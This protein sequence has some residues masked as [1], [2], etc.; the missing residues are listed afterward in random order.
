M[1]PCTVQNCHLHGMAVY[2]KH[3]FQCAPRSLLSPKPSLWHR[4]SYPSRTAL[5]VKN[6]TAS[7]GDVRRQGLNPWLRTIPWRR[8]WQPTPVFLPGESQ[9][10]RS[11]RG[12]TAHGVARVGHDLAT[13]ATITSRG[14]FRSRDQTR[15][16]YISCICRQVLYH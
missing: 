15:I 7:A 3:Q 10:Q 1:V 13:K 8:A 4:P 11:L 12:Y 14:P 2:S 5:V 6:L 9:G 16:P